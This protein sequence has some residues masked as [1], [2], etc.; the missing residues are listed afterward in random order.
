MES[1]EEKR[2]I[3]IRRFFKC[4]KQVLGI[5]TLYDALDFKEPDSLKLEE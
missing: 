2:S 5:M 1:K 4:E 3:K